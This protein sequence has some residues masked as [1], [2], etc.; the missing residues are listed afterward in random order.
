MQPDLFALF[1]VFADLQRDH[2]ARSYLAHTMTVTP[3]NLSEVAET[4]R[5]VLRIR[6]DMMS[7]QPAAY[8]GGEAFGRAVL[9]PSEQ[10][11]SEGHEFAPWK[12]VSRACF[13][14]SPH[15]RR[16]IGLLARL[17]YDEAQYGVSQ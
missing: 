16:A 11:H 4:V 8:I 9:G 6:F 5:A 14:L 15:R 17:R 2:H 7:F 13:F 3:S 10:P 12:H 1:A